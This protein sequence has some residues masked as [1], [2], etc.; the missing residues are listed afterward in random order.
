MNKSMR[1]I[2]IVIAGLLFVI[3]LLWEQ[4]GQLK[5]D[6]ADGLR[7]AFAPQIVEIETV[8]K[9]ADFEHFRDLTHYNRTRQFLGVLLKSEIFVSEIRKREGEESFFPSLRGWCVPWKQ[10]FS[11][12]GKLAYEWGFV[13]RMEGPDTKMFPTC[14]VYHYNGEEVLDLEYLGN[15][16][17]LPTVEEA[18]IAI[19]KAL[20]K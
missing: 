3:F 11:P 16:H 13:F 15:D 5:M 4:K 12:D 18:K 19:I 17:G 8:S 2:Y 14:L 6:L 20:K 7:N 10:E 1:L 9:G